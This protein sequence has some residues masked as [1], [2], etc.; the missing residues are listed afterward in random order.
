MRVV[1]ETNFSFPNLVKKFKKFEKKATTDL[2]KAAAK[3]AKSKIKS[4]SLRPLRQS[5]VDLR[6]RDGIKGIKPLHATGRLFKSIKGDSKGFHIIEY[7]KK[8]NDGFTTSTSSKF[9]P[10]FRGKKIAPRP[11][12]EPDEE[13]QEKYAE[14]IIKAIDKALGTGSVIN[15]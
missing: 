3:Q 10:N 9:I 15:F 12:I 2:Y 4:G 14:E 5:T 11:F 1:I 13:I 7:G 6:K 8:H